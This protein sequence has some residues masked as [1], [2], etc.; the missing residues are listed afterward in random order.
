MKEIKL[1]DQNSIKKDENQKPNL[2]IILTSELRK[3][4]DIPRIVWIDEPLNQK[5]HV[6]SIIDNLVDQKPYKVVIIKMFIR[7]LLKK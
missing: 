3:I 4:P 6:I 7:I 2:N 5:F 1:L